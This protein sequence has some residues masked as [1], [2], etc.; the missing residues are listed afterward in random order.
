MWLKSLDI[1]LEKEFGPDVLTQ[2]LA[3]MYEGEAQTPT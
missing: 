2:G 1:D 3:F